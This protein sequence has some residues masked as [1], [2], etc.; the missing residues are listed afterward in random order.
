MT[1]QNNSETRSFMASLCDHVS[2]P[3]C[4]SVPTTAGFPQNERSKRQRQKQECLSSQ[5]SHLII[6]LCWS[7]K[8]AKSTWEESTYKL[9]YQER[10][11]ISRESS[12]QRKREKQALS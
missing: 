3:H 11:S 9:E 4:S 6:V 12:K 10:E 5:K 1:E 8:P 2:S 7:Q